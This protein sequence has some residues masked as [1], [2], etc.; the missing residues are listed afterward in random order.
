MNLPHALA[1]KELR[2]TDGANLTID[3]Y[4]DLVLLATGSVKEAERRA[5]ARRSA[6]LRA[7]KTP[8]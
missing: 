2:E 4:Y 6:I 1:E 7:G 5:R 3:G 8:T